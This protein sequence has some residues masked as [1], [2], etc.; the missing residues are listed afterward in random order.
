MQ[1]KSSAQHFILHTP[2]RQANPERWKV[3]GAAELPS[4]PARSNPAS[5]A[6]RHTLFLLTGRSLAP[7]TWHRQLTSLHATAPLTAARRSA[8]TGACC[9]SQVRYPRTAP[10]LCMT[11]QLL[12]HFAGLC[13]LGSQPQQCPLVRRAGPAAAARLAGPILKQAPTFAHRTPRFLPF[14]TDRQTR[15][16]RW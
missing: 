9:S 14:L 7:H 6:L 2:I 4:I 13:R 10:C 1:K 8:E 12:W 11:Q 16:F 3:D 5:A 15:H